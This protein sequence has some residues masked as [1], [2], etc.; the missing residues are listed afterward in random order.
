M[1]QTAINVRLARPHE[2]NKVAHDLAKKIAMDAAK[3]G[4]PS[5]SAWVRYLI[6]RAGEREIKAYK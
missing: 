3:A 4:A 2:P 5:K 6:R 1:N